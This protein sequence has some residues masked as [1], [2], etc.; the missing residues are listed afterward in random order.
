MKSSADGVHYFTEELSRHF[1]HYFISTAYGP[2]LAHC[3]AAGAP[4]AVYG[5][6]G[7]DHRARDQYESAALA[8]GN[9]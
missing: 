4:I 7:S 9:A 1:E 2:G 8:D 3:L 5:L 6:Q